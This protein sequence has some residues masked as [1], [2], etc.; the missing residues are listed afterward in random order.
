MPALSL[1]GQTQTA[2]STSSGDTHSGT[3][4]NSDGTVDE[5][6]RVNGGGT[7]YSQIDNATD[8]IIPNS[9]ASEKTYHVRATQIRITDSGFEVGALGSWININTSPEWYQV[10]KNAGGNGNSEWDITFDISDDGGSTTLVSGRY[11]HNAVRDV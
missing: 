11:D 8:W 4:F 7:S 6:E 2:T 5:L 3:R 9:Q 1:D 10:R